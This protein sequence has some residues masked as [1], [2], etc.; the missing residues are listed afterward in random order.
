MTET[1][2]ETRADQIEIGSVHVEPADDMIDHERR[3]TVVDRQLADHSDG[4]ILWFE[5]I[6]GD[7]PKTYRRT[8]YNDDMLAVVR[9]PGAVVK[10]ADELAAGDVIRGRGVIR[11]TKAMGVHGRGTPRTWT[12]LWFEGDGMARDVNH[13]ALYE[14]EIDRG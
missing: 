1:L 6:G 13:A 3:W 12:R 8:Y 9:P 10:R 14:V 11:R 7:D 2:T 4:V 5:R